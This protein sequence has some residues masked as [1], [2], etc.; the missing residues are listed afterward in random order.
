MFTQFCVAVVV[1]FQGLFSG[2]S[3]VS[4]TLETTS[5]SL[6]HST[7]TAEVLHIIDGDTIDV[8]FSL[9][10]VTT[11]V[12][13]IGINTPE[14]YPKDSSMEECGSREATAANRALVAAQTVTLVTDAD[15]FD[16][17]N[18]L[19]AYVYVGEIFVNEELVRRGY[20]TTLSINPN[21][22]HRNLFTDRRDEAKAERLGNWQTCPNWN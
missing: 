7:T 21:T 5:L 17:Y 11:R 16:S 13:Y 10:T 4:S 12:R 19:L 9:S 8:R 1:F 22:R 6:P 15:P 2:F 20:A 18:R 3:P 14:P